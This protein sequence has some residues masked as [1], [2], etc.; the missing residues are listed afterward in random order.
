MHTSKHACIYPFF[1]IYILCN[2]KKKKEQK[3]EQGKCVCESIK[4]AK[5]FIITLSLTKFYTPR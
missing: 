3:E 4:R 5:T 2:Q 1:K